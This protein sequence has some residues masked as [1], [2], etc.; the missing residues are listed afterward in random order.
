MTTATVA[1]ETVLP[2]DAQITNLRILQLLGSWSCPWEN[3]FWGRGL[4]LGLKVASVK[5]RRP[6][7]LLVD[8]EMGGCLYTQDFFFFFFNV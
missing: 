4:G 2:D 7:T 6:R 3:G 1:N 8:D 5:M